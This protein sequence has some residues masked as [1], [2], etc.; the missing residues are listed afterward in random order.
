[1]N[2]EEPCPNVCD[3][4]HVLEDVT[5]HLSDRGYL[6]HEVFLPCCPQYCAK[7]VQGGQRHTEERGM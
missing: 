4:V 5:E 7:H 2:P 1:M 6:C 3:S